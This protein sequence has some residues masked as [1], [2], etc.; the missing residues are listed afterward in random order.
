MLAGKIDIYCPNINICA[1]YYT[2]KNE[3]KF[4]NDNR[5]WRQSEKESLKR[6][7]C[8]L[9]WIDKKDVRITNDLEKYNVGN[10]R[11]LN[12]YF[13]YIKLDF[14]NKEVNLCKEIIK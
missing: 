3:P 10:V 2:R 11:S 6:A 14:K 1:H 7:K 12:E 4:W 8:I 13:K 9:K 5:N